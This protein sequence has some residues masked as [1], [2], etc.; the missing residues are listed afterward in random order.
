M[1]NLKGMKEIRDYY[2]RSDAT[3]LDLIRGYGFPAVKNP[4]QW[5]ST[6]EQ[7]DEWV[8]DRVQQ[9]RRNRSEKNW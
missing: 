7:I 8:N 5:E 4:G 9:K 3:I 1:A 6:T 2:R